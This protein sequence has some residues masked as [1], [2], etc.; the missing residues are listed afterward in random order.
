M[1]E[2]TEELN[3]FHV[4]LL[5]LLLDIAV[6]LIVSGAHS[7]KTIRIVKRFAKAYGFDV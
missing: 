7:G 6:T 5:E 1:Q 4:Q 2:R 3:T